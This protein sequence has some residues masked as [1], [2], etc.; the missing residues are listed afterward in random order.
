[1]RIFWSCAAL[2]ALCIG[3][4]I[5]AGDEARVK[6]GA[7]A[8]KSF[9]V[10]Y[11][12]TIPKH[13]VVRARINGKGPYNFILDTGAPA[14]FVA[15]KVGKQVGAKPDDNGWATFDSFEIE[16]AAKLTKVKGRVETPFQLEGM[17]GL[18]LAGVEIHGMIGYN[19]LARYKVQIDFARDKMV[20]TPLDFKPAEPL[21]MGRKAGSATPG[22]E[23][24]GT[25]MKTLGG[26]LGVR[27]APKVALRGFLGMTVADGEDYPTVKA[28]LDEGPAAK[29]GIR[30]GDTLT[31][32]N[33]RGVY[34]RSD[35]Y[36][37]ARK[38]R[39]G[40]AVKATIIRGKTRSE[41]TITVG[42]GI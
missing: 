9:E 1:M 4:P 8:A 30:A 2:A 18:G 15:V 16:G 19:V 28:V 36:R 38:L 31:R 33:G 37:E 41:V 14:L 29:A 27:A 22:L 13:V 11:S 25:I 40:Q 24:L 10:P 42:E 39:A 35:V 5:P 7:K 21:G 32:L 17:N 3:P 12:L 34:D 20:W 26:T 23:A 6:P